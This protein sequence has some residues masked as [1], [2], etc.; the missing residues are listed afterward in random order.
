MSS[1]GPVFLEQGGYLEARLS[2]CPRP[3]DQVL[4]IVDRFDLGV[5]G[6]RFAPHVERVSC[7][8]TINSVDPKKFGARVAQNRGL[9]VDV[10]TDPAEALRWLLS[11][12]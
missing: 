2:A 5:L 8:G 10:F 6:G 1:P 4:T 9:K 7:L 11:G 3:A 12:D